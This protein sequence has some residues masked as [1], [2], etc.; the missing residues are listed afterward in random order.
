M[1]LVIPSWQGRTAKLFTKLQS[2]L[3][4]TNQIILK[5]MLLIAG[6]KCDH[7]ETAMLTHPSISCDLITVIKAYHVWVVTILM[8]VASF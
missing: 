5:V 8:Y 1:S 2:L 4:Y 6:V 3:K 7:T